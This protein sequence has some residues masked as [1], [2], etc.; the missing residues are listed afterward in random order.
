MFFAYIHYRPDGRPFYVGKGC[1]NR[2][3]I[4]KRNVHYNRIIVKYGAENIRIEILECA[5]ENEAFDLEKMLIREL[6]EKGFILANMTDGGEGISNPPPEVRE[7]I[8]AGQRG[9]KSHRRSKKKNI[10][11][12]K[13]Q[14]T[15]S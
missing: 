11:V 8:A 9:R 14:K 6:K 10:Q 2:H 15:K 1:G 4:M 3:A 5:T 12:W 7:K 13:G